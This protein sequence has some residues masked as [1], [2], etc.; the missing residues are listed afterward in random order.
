MR[1]TSKIRHRRL[2]ATRIVLR[3][4]ELRP[5]EEMT[6]ALDLGRRMDA[7][8]VVTG[9]VETF[10]VRRPAELDKVSAL[11]IP[12]GEST[13]LTRL[14]DRV[15]LREELSEANKWLNS[16]AKKAGVSDFGAFMNAGYMGM[17]RMLNRQML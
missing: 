12:G 3:A 14:V 17:Y 13:T 15:G 6:R 5:R 4:D 11:I 2:V 1:L 7:D 16:K 9:K 8:L 10:G